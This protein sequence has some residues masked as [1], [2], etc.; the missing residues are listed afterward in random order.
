MQP[1]PR[2]DTASPLLP[3]ARFFISPPPGSCPGNR[4]TRL[5]SVLRVEFLVGHRKVHDSLDQARW[6]PKL[7]R[8]MAK[9]AAATRLLM[10]PGRLRDGCRTPHPGQISARESMWAKAV[11]AILSLFHGI[12]PAQCRAAPGPRKRDVLSDIASDGSGQQ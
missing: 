1:S 8:R 10:L 9:I 12:I 7:P 11:D 5:P 2:A 4:R 3:S 6:T